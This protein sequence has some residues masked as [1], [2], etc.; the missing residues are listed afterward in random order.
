MTLSIYFV[1]LVM[2]SKK[3]ALPE[4]SI[5]TNFE[6]RVHTGFDPYHGTFVGLPAQWKSIVEADPNQ[7]QQHRLSGD[8]SLYRPQKV[9]HLI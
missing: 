6:H 9:S 5:P 4:I 2:A 1:S 3:K 8:P 7:Q